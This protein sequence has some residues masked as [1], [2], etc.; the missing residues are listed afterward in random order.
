[1]DNQSDGPTLGPAVSPGA[2][3]VSNPGTFLAGTV[4]L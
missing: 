3:T 2:G 1:M 4:M